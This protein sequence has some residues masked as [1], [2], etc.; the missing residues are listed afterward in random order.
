MSPHDLDCCLDETC[1]G[2][3]VNLVRQEMI[4][5]QPLSNKD[6]SLRGVAK[7]AVDFS[8]LGCLSGQKY[9]EQLFEHVRVSGFE[10]I[11]SVGQSI[12]FGDPVRPVMDYI[13]Q[14]STRQL[15]YSRKGSL[16]F[17]NKYLTAF[18]HCPGSSGWGS[19]AITT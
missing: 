1:N 2:R 13:E 16:L 7:M 4:A 9:G 17:M 14:L 15:V 18:R 6:K 11:L 12:D 3:I 5:H 19:V 8:K 10:K